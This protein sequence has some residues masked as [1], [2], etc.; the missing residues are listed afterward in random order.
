M[1][2]LRQGTRRELELEHFW[3]HKGGMV[4]KFRGVDSISAAE[5]LIG[6]ELQ[7]PREQRAELG[8]GE[9]YVSDLL[10]CVV[11]ADARELG[12]I[13]DVDFSAG[14]APLLVVRQGGKE[15]L[16]PFAEEFV[17]ELDL[18]GRRLR[19]KLPEGLLELDA[20]LSPEEKAEQKKKSSY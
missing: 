18:A 9:A 11:I 16:L 4:L 3:P 20:P 15:Y 12:P 10:G 7:I 2:V 5:G 17:E 19:M 6:A 8:L 13:S 1:H 14:T